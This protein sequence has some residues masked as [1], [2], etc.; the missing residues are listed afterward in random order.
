MTT[1]LSITGLS[2]DIIGAMLIFFNSPKMSYGIFMYNKEEL[3]YLNKK[4][5]KMHRRTQ[6]GAILLAIGF[7]LQI[8][9][10]VVQK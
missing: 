10:M 3:E 4:A 2:I 9:G 5:S 7:I 6:I 1:I 8:V